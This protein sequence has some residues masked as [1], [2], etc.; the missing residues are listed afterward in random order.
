MKGKSSFGSKLIYKLGLITYIS[1]VQYFAFAFEHFG[2]VKT[3]QRC[4]I[5]LE[6][7]A[8]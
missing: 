8:Q 3:F 6:T 5:T 7:N 2:V 4:I 1:I